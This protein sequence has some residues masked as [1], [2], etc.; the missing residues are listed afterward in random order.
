MELIEFVDRVRD[1]KK[2]DIK[3]LSE[4][5][6]QYP[7]IILIGNGGSNSIASHMAID[8]TKFLGKRCFVPN[9]G[10][11]LSMVVNDYGYANAYSKFIEQCYSRGNQLAILIS[12]S[13]RS[14]NILSAAATCRRL[15][16]PVV[17]LSGFEKGNPLSTLKYDSIKINYWVDS[18]DYG[19]VELVHHAFLH[20]IV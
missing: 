9:S 13:G 18:K 12:S 17:L 5:V 8:Y 4:L 3:L 2:E 11:M 15:S 20:S 14:V 7:E 1:I 19:V 6:S 16:I 10:D